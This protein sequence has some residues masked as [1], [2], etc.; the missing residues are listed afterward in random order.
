M[1]SDQGSLYSDP[2]VKPRVR[3]R[4]SSA[5][6]EAGSCDLTVQTEALNAIPTYQERDK[7]SL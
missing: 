5:S 6:G 2:E 1:P 4:K 3:D 7:N